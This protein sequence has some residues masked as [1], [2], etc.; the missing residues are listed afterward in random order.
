MATKDTM[1]W[2]LWEGS[3]RLGGLLTAGQI[4]VLAEGHNIEPELLFDLSRSIELA[5]KPD[6]NIRK[7]APT[8]EEGE[9][10]SVSCSRLR[11]FWGRY[12]SRT[13]LRMPACPILPTCIATT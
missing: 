8:F 7:P 1:P 11:L 13:C 9:G 6:L 12:V 4:G 5:F 2:V 10:Q 3:P